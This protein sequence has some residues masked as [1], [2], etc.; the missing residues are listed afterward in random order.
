VLDRVDLFECATRLMM[1][2]FV[3]LVKDDKILV[4]IL[5]IMDPAR[6]NWDAR[7]GRER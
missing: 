3:S 1:A 6:G 4:K 2:E 5:V 7:Y